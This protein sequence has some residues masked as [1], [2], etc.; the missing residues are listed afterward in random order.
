MGD[1]MD[2]CACF[3]SHEFAMRRLLAIVSKNMEILFNFLKLLHR[4]E[5]D[6]PVPCVEN[7]YYI[8]RLFLK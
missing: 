5:F 3:W 1:E 6:E 7:V 4:E 8:R 2:E